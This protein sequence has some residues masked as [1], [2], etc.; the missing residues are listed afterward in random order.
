VTT[1]STEPDVFLATRTAVCV[2]DGVEYSLVAGKTRVRAGHPLLRAQGA[3]FELE[4]YR[5]DYDWPPS[6]R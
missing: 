3:S 1:K 6:R 4:I 2:H 5:I